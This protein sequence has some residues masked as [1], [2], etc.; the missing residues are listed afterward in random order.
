[1]VSVNV[2]AKIITLGILA[3]SSCECDKDYEIGEYLKDCICRKGIFDDLV[4]TGDE[5]LDMSEAKSTDCNIL[6]QIMDF[7]CWSISKCVYCCW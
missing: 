4:V 5:I 2:S 7:L 1:M 3:F 6:K